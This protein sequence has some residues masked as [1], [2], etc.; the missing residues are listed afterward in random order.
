[1]KVF[2]SKWDDWGDENSPQTRQQGTDKTDK[3]LSDCS[4]D[5]QKVHLETLWPAECL[6]AESRFGHRHARI[7]PFLGKRVTTPLGPG[8]LRA[9]YSTVAWVHLDGDV[10]LTK[11]DWEAIRG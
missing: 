11:I 9:V 4:S 6:E 1:M 7:Y 2:H 3:S 10:R 5:R 8:T